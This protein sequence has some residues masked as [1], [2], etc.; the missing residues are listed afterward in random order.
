MPGAGGWLKIFHLLN[1]WR[2]SAAQPPLAEHTEWCLGLTAIHPMLVCCGM[3]IKT[4]TT[5][6]PFTSLCDLLLKLGHQGSGQ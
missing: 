2:I 6:L 5:Q 4:H 1:G 3:S